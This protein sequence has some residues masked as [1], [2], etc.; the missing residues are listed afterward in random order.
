MRLRSAALL[1]ALTLAAASAPGCARGGHVERVTRP[2][3]PADVGSLPVD[4][5]ILR[6]AGEPDADLPPAN[7]QGIVC[8]RS[9]AA[10]ARGVVLEY[11]TCTDGLRCEA[12]VTG[13]TIDVHAFWFGQAFVLCT[14]PNIGEARCRTTTPLPPD[15][16]SIRIDGSPRVIG[17]APSAADGGVEACWLWP[18]RTPTRSALHGG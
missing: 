14:A 16:T 7:F 10:G 17:I 9:D 12:R 15:A 18:D 1:A 6:D 13:H 11:V 3:P 2:R 5:F 8:L 4:P